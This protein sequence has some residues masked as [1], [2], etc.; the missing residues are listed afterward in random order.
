[1]EKYT[2]L[3]DSVLVCRGVAFS[4]T[5][6]SYYY[7][8]TILCTWFEQQQ[9]H[10]CLVTKDTTYENF[11]ATAFSQYIQLV[12]H[13]VFKARKEKTT[14][15]LS[16][17]YIWQSGR[18]NPIPT[19]KVKLTLHTW[20]INSFGITIRTEITHPCRNYEKLMP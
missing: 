14:G 5:G 19:W 13:L 4:A 3:S 10:S 15:L 6:L 20:K 17:I 7:A 16:L 11:Q 2:L 1:M 18:S 8:N 12:L 9:N